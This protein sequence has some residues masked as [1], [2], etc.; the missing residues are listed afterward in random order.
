MDLSAYIKEFE[1][2]LVE[3]YLSFGMKGSYEWETRGLNKKD[4]ITYE[5]TL[6][7]EIKL[8]LILCDCCYCCYPTSADHQALDWSLMRPKKWKIWPH[9][10]IEK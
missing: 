2:L 9:L 3:D 8:K 6:K 10:V 4:K 1:L 7:K 5:R